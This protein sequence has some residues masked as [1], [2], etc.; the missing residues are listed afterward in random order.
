M[1]QPSRKFVSLSF[2]CNKAMSPANL[3]T[4]TKMAA[5]KKWRWNL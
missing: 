4:I 2:F 5:A 3:P 1:R